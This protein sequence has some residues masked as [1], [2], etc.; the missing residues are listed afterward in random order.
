MKHF[1]KFCSTC[2]VKNAGHGQQAQ[3]RQTNKLKLNKIQVCIVH[4]IDE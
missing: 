1:F 2:A 3:N 4:M